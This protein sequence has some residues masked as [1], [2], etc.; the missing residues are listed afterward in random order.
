MA[1]L[2]HYGL[3]DEATEFHV[4]VNGGEESAWAAKM[5]LPPKADVIFHGTQCRNEC[6]TIR[7]LEQWLPGHEGW[8]VFY[9]HVKGGTS[10]PEKKWLN[11]KWWACMMKNLVA[12]W[13]RC[14]TD[15][16]AAHDAVGVHWMVPPSTP[17]GQRIFAGNF[18]WAK[19][20]FLC[21]LP[22]IMERD[23]IKVSGLDSIESR[24]ESEVWLGNGSRIPRIKD[25]HGPRWTPAR[26]G[27]CPA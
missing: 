21:S 18:W 20:G 10:G 17:V 19:G 23:R 25:Y 12:N 3:L 13:R 11:D 6:R 27:E 5:F 1:A 2:K 14:V 15:L 16:S 9:F 4:G 26:I 24:Y 8:N 22:S 7:S